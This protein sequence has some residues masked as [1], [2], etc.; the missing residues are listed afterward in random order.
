MIQPLTTAAISGLTNFARRVFRQREYV[1]PLGRWGVEKNPNQQEYVSNWA[2]ADH[3][4]VCND[5]LAEITKSQTPGVDRFPK[6]SSTDS[7]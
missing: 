5:H 1:K 3:C 6:N 7:K 2:S 4:G